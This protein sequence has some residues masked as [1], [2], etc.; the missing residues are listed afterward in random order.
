[1]APVRRGGVAVSR[2]E[3]SRFEPQRAVRFA[4]RLGPV[5]DQDNRR[6]ALA[7]QAAKLAQDDARVGLV[8][9]ARGLVGEH[10]RRAVQHRAAK[11]HPLLLAAGE[12]GGIVIPPVRHAETL[13][14][15][16]RVAPRRARSRPT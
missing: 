2:P 10:E 3:A 15:R 7:D 13:H 8:E 16:E 4:R 1:M 9:A 5:C 6:G 14:Q 12:L 11:G